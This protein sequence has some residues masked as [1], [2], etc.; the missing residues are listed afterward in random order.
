[1]HKFGQFICKHRKIILIIAFL[2][3]I[4]SVIGMKATKIN[5]DILVYLPDDVETIQGEKILAEDFHMGA[6]SVVIL[7]N[8]P[9][10]DILTLEDKIKEIDNVEK[11]AS[12]AD[13]IGAGVPVEMLPDTIKNHLYKENNTIMLVTFKEQIS[14]DSTMEAVGKLRDITDERC[15]VSG[16]TATVIDTRALS[17]SEVAIYVM[18]AVAL[19]LLVLEIA[20]DSYLAPILLLLNI[21][22][23]VLYNMGSNVILG[24]TSY[25]TKAI[26][27]VLQLGVTMDFAIFLYHSYMQ[28][29]E[30]ASSNDEAMENAIGKTLISVIGSSLTTIAGFL[31]LC[32]MNLTLG[33]DIG[34]VMAKGV[35]F[36]V[37]C[38]VTVLPAMILQF[39]TLIEKT[40]HKEILPKFTHIKNFVM[41]HYKAIIVAFL[42]ILPIAFYGYRHTDIYYNLD[43]SL[44]KDLPSVSANNELK[45]KF[46]MVSMELLLVDKNIPTYQTN[47]ML[48]EIESLDGIEWT[49]GYSK[50]A[51]RGIPKEILPENVLSVFQNDK[52]QMILINS[53][54]E[55][56][57]DELNDQVT[58]VNE[59][60]KKYDENAI[61]AGEGPLMKDLVEI[62]NHDFN[63]V[64]IVSI[65]VIFVIMFFVLRS[66]SLP[67]I[68]IAVIEFAIF[69]NMGIPYYTHVELPFVASIVIGTIQLGATIDYAILIT[70]KYIV[71]RKG[72]KTKQEAIDEALGT[73]IGSIAISGLCFFGATFGVG[74]YSQ[75]EMIGSLCTL[76]SRGAIISM[77]CV[78]TVLP[79]FLMVFDKLICHTTIGM[80]NVRKEG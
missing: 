51:E 3:L 79:S 73:S 43:K 47:Q 78:I 58:K 75:I 66:A 62:S 65:A 7:E 39:N 14:S 20:L 38:V 10:K 60:I 52:Y 80:K 35:L 6:F 70:T 12:I 32:S 71:G 46:N 45:E 72:G 27:A 1:M 29:K 25:I 59:I 68:L 17:D 9:T 50:I 36:G 77:L 13:V 15:K 48:S 30:T 24:Q 67:F 53:K 49:M 57:T 37:I 21:G 56:A 8:M 26:S 4:P 41:K 31:A 18:I 34:L 69:I 28:E 33:R 63:S 54:Y 22:I 55:M 42:I 64:N 76:M 2:L 44:P 40:K 19:C 5:Y 11:V 61:L 23:A 16:M 74:M